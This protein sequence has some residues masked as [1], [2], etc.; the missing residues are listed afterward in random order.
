MPLLLAVRAVCILSVLKAVMIL[1]YLIFQ[2]RFEG[3]RVTIETFL[4]W[5]AK[6]D[7]ELAELRGQKGKD[8]A[9]SKKLTG[10]DFVFC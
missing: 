2:K 1:I 3:T 10:T 6:F 8:D 9:S 5:K 4:V 7:N